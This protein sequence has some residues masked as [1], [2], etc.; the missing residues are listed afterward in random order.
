[1]RAIVS[2]R[3][4]EKT[5]YTEGS[6]QG[7]AVLKGL[8]FDINEGEFAALTGQSGSGKSTLLNLLGCLD[9]STAGSYLLNGADVSSMN[10]SQLSNMRSRYIGFIFQSF[11]LIGQLNVLE[12]VELPLFYQ[13]VDARRRLERAKEILGQVGLSDRL[14]HLP[15]QLS[16]GE[17]QRVAIARALIT[18]PLLLLADE[19]TGNLDSKTG[20]EI[21]ALLHK[22]HEDGATILMVTHD[23]GISE[24]LPRAIHMKDGLIVE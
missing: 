11:N 23:P 24:S 13:K 18:R 3:D 19:P 22:L 1:M 10:D 7:L 5:Y 21:V 17:C 9:R 4:L 16:G 14:H 6:G 2:I 15:N 8:S 20:D 12:N